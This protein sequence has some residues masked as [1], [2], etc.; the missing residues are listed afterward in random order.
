M[1]PRRLYRSPYLVPRPLADQ[2]AQL[3]R[4]GA[5]EPWTCRTLRDHGGRHCTMERQSIN[6]VLYRGE[7][8]GVPRL[9]FSRLFDDCWT[10]HYALPRKLLAMYQAPKHSKYYTF[11]VTAQI[12]LAKFRPPSKYDLDTLYSQARKP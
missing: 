7:R 6:Y 11:Y 5:L 2:A 8:L 10:L 12:R 9:R 3:I 4:E 1:K